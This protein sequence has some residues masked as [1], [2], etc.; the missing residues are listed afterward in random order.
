M[1]KLLFRCA[2]SA[3]LGCILAASAAAGDLKLTLQNGR[4]T[5]IAQDVPLR[6]IL[7]EWAQIG[8]TRIVNGDRLSGPNVTLQ[9]INVPEKEALDILLRSAA[10]YVAAPRPVPI[11]TASM[12]DRILI[13]ATSHAP[14]VMASAPSAMAPAFQ[15]PPQ[16]VDDDDEP[17]NVNMPPA[18]RPQSPVVGA[19]PGPQPPNMPTQPGYN[20]A[21]PGTS[22]GPGQ[23][24]VM[25]SPRPGA[26]PAAQPPNGGVN[27]YQPTVVR[28]VGPGGPGGPG[29]GTVDD[30]TIR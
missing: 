13:M 27:P 25:T 2:L 14:A 19:F 8:Q 3:A 16:P 12:Y 18:M 20:P 23:V 4:A 15:R 5:V 10:G 30:Q 22:P 6:Q 21:M 17:M 1:K 7:Q 29:G 11:S 26:L 9:L 28:P 24:P